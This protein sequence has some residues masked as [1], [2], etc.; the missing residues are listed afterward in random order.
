MIGQLVI[1]INSGVGYYS[2]Y[3]P[4]LGAVY[5][6]EDVYAGTDWFVCKE[7]GREENQ[8]RAFSLKHFSPAC[9]LAS[10]LYGED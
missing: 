1:C 8:L 9:S 10:V 3:H 6:I 5:K 7:V 4:K 2:F